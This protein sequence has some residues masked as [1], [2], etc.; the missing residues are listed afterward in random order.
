MRK[1][2]SAMTALVIAGLLA[3]FAPAAGALP[4]GP[5]VSAAGGR[6]GYC[7]PTSGI[8]VGHICVLLG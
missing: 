3:T 1:P 2:K 5:H 6:D 4:P 8:P 7:A